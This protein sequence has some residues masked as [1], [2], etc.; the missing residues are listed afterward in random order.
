MALSDGAEDVGQAS[1]KILCQ[2]NQAAD[3]NRPKLA[4]ARFFAGVKL[5]FIRD[6]ISTLAAIREVEKLSHDQM[7]AG[8]LE[9]VIPPVSKRETTL[10]HCSHQP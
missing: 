3:R 1:G 7:H 8:G 5:A 2:N 4:G 6:D 9:T 10:S